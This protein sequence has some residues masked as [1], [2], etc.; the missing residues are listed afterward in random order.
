MKKQTKKLSLDNIWALERISKQLELGSLDSVVRYL[1][2]FYEKTPQNSS[3]PQ[4]TISR[5]KPLTKKPKG[6]KNAKKT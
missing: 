4:K 5:T 3:N 6:K 1:I 2:S